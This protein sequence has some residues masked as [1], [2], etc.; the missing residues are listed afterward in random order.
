MNFEAS[1]IPDIRLEGHNFEKFLADFDR[2]TSVEEQQEALNHM[3]PLERRERMIASSSS[4]V[5][6]RKVVYYRYMTWDK[7]KELLHRGHQVPFDYAVTPEQKFSGEE[8][9]ELKEL[10]LDYVDFLCEYKKTFS[11][12][13]ADDMRNLNLDHIFKK[14][15]TDVADE[16]IQHVVSTLN[17][18]TVLAF[19]KKHVDRQYLKIRHTGSVLQKF[20]PYL[21]ASV[22]AP[23]SSL[24]GR[25][26]TKVY[27]EMVIPDKQVSLHPEGV[28]GEKE[29]LIE[30]IEREHIVRVYTS[31]QLWTELL[32][33]P[34]SVIGRYAQENN[35][36]PLEAIESW[37]WREKTEDYLPVGLH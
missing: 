24:Q 9:S 19:I 3:F 12:N 25:K 14:I 20:S 37:R 7:L 36:D 30:K 23:I 26:G 34:E 17:Y 4:D 10:L 31:D 16:E 35:K 28:Q 11:E 2:A 5:R 18:T 22:G 8:Q 21:S 1:I 15:F 27:V 6:G 29:V 33:N 13:A 32:H